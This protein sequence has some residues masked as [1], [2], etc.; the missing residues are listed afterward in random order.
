[1]QLWQGRFTKA[2]DSRVNDFNSSIRFDR[3]MAAQDIA[4]SMAHAAM[5]TGQGILSEAGGAA[6][7]EGLEGLLADLES[8]ALSIDPAAEDI[9]TFVEA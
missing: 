1:M 5:L 4:G 9:H 3:R 8:G 2:V 7:Q 6:T